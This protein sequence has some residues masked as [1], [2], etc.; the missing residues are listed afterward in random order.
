MTINEIITNL[1][2]IEV[3]LD[4]NGLCFEEEII[5]AF[6]DY[7]IDGETE[8]ITH[9]DGNIYTAYI[10][11]ADADIFNIKTYEEDNMLYVESV[12]IS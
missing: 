9:K 11:H 10:N 12:W 2:C 1:E 3:D 4:V 7:E 6:E 5:C 8:V